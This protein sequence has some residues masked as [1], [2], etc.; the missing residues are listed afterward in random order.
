MI[1]SSQFPG[2]RT[3]HWNACTSVPLRRF[4]HEVDEPSTQGCWQAVSFIRL[5]NASSKELLEGMLILCYERIFFKE[6]LK[7][8]VS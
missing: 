3:L 1:S 2:R 7:R 5:M 6:L 8:N 4:V